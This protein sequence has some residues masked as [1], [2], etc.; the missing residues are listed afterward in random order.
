MDQDDTNPNEQTAEALTVKRPERSL[1]HQLLLDRLTKRTALRTP[2][3]PRAANDTEAAAPPA[4]ADERRASPRRRMLK[5]GVIAFNGTCSSL[6]CTVRDLSDGGAR[7]KVDP[8]VHVPATFELI[9]EIDGLYA[10][11]AIAWRKG[12]DVGVRFTEP[13]RSGVKLRQQVITPRA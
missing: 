7:L 10:R 3:T 11:G 2:P 9:I 6:R 8:L 13:I 5:A 12:S 4:I 1:N